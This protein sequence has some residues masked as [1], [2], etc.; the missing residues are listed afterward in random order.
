MNRALG[1]LLLLAATA[2][3]AQDKNP[4]TSVAR[5]ILPRQQKNMVGGWPILLADSS[6][7]VAPPRSTPL[8]LLVSLR[9]GSSLAFCGRVGGR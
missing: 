3:L 5:E 1:I 2:V 9:A 8:V 4:V 6:N 7:G